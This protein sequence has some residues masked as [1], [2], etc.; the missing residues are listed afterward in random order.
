MQTKPLASALFVAAL[1]LSNLQKV[2]CLT[3]PGLMDEDFD[4]ID[5]IGMEKITMTFT[6]ADIESL[7]AGSGGVAAS[8]AS[9]L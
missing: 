5:D 9:G 7:D 2:R 1:T 3:E 8:P 6:G 4:S